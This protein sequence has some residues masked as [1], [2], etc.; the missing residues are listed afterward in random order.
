M[1]MALRVLLGAIVH[2]IIP[3]RILSTFYL[4]IV[5]CTFALPVYHATQKIYMAD[6]GLLVT[7]SF[8]DNEL[9]NNELYRAILLDKLSINEGMLMENVVAQILRCNR[10]RLYFYSRVD[11]NNRKNAMEIDFLVAGQKKICPVEVKSSAY[12]V[13]S[14]LDKFR[15]RFSSKLG[16][17]YILY[18]K[19]IMVKENII[20]L[21]IYMAM[22]L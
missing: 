7:H 11:T 4:S 12:R 10:R 1:Y 19:D 5:Y 20:H 13:H 16:D 15:Q 22:F 21:P 18:T 3:K 14:S 6:T 2:E 9:I 8:R 17:A